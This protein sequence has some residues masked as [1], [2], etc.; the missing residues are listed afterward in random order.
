[1]WNIS[2]KM[3]FPCFGLALGLGL[4][5]PAAVQSQEREKDMAARGQ[6][7]FA[8]A[9]GCACHTVPKGT[10]HAGGRAFPMPFVAYSGMA[11]ED[12]KALIVYLRTLKP[13]RKENLQP[14]VYVSLFR[15]LVTPLW[16]KLFGRF[17]NPPARAPKNSV[18]RG[19][20]LVEHVSLCDDCHTPRNL[21][22]VPRRALYLAGSK[23]GIL[24]EEI[25]NI[26]PD[27]ETGIGEWSRNDIAELLLTGTKPDLDNVQGLMAE[28]IEAGYKNMKR[29]DALAIADYIKSIPPIV[30]KIK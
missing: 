29:E 9:G 1:M 26:T 27:K 3:F 16:L 21:L 17:S 6:Y 8:V 15:P 24:G 12:L 2:L 28:L 11:E 18:E 4:L 25:P 7:I 23:V 5:A 14:K 13:V 22:M 20:Y 30:N 19:R 10:P